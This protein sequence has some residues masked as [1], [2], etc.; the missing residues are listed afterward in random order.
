MNIVNIHKQCFYLLI[1]EQRECKLIYVKTPFAFNWSFHC[2][3]LQLMVLFL[4]PKSLEIINRLKLKDISIDIWINCPICSEM[5]YYKELINN[6]MARPKAIIT[7]LCQPVKELVSS[8]IAIPSPNATPI[9]SLALS[10][11]SMTKPPMTT[12]W[13]VLEIKRLLRRRYY[14]YSHHLGY[15]QLHCN[16]TL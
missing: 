2:S 9:W 7:F 13:S 4:K 10:L 6:W 11:V 12:N 16:H 14:R 3:Y 8:M 15:G 1:K 5:I